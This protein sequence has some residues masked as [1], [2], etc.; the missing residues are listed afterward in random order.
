MVLKV[1]LLVY[2]VIESDIKIKRFAW[3]FKYLK[4]TDFNFNL[5]PLFSLLQDISKV[6]Q[7]L[8]LMHNNLQCYR[9][10]LCKNDWI[11]DIGWGRLR[12]K[13]YLVFILV[14]S[15]WPIRK[16]GVKSSI[17]PRDLFTHNQLEPSLKLKLTL[18]L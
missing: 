4:L 3:K 16:R 17:K 14:L 9:C 12:A 15:T 2:V 8:L 1:K 18:L 10:I 5:L 7:C 11:H 6:L 13:T